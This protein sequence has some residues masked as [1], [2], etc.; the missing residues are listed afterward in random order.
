V[1]Q[2]AELASGARRAEEDDLVFLFVVVALDKV[3]LPATSFGSSSA[4]AL[5]ANEL[6]RRHVQDDAASRRCP[7]VAKSDSSGR[8]VGSRRSPG[9]IVLLS[10][11]ANM[12]S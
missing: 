11:R 2:V 3:R 9:Q 1:P 5:D 12:R 7:K 6:G 8:P 4:P 10:D